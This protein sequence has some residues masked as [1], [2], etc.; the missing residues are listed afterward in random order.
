[1]LFV[2]IK[3]R[4]TKLLYCFLFFPRA[5]TVFLG[6]FVFC[7]VQDVSCWIISMWFCVNRHKCKKHKQTFNLSICFKYSYHTL[8]RHLK[9]EMS[10]AC[11]FTSMQHTIS[12]KLRWEMS[13]MLSNNTCMDLFLLLWFLL[14][15]SHVVRIKTSNIG[16]MND[17]GWYKF[18]L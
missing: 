13:E 14:G 11:I 7:I 16:A 10:K 12:N 2:K 5:A 1:M 15:T 18:K 6:P 3:R 17:K 8:A 4:T 9:E